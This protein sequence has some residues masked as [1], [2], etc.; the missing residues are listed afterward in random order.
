MG[1]NQAHNEVFYHFL[2]S[3]LYV[4]LEIAYNDSLQQCLTS[5]GCKTHEKNFLGPNVGQTGENQAQ[6]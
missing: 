6:N 3:R 5:S 2:E 1:L 4:L